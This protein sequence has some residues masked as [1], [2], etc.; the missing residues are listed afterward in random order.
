MDLL[1]KRV[2]VIGLSESGF[3]AAKLLKRVKARVRVSELGDSQLFRKRAEGLSDVECEIGAHTKRFIEESDLIVASP[4]VPMDA[5]PLIWARGRNIPVIS[6][7]E[8]GYLFCSVPIV[9]VTGTNG[10]STTT[11]LIYEMLKSNNIRSYLLGN[12]G[13]PICEDILD[14]P[15]GSVIS[16][17]VSSFQLQTIKSFRPHIAVLLNITQ[18]H[19]DRHSGMEE[20]RNTKL[21]IF[22][23]Q[24][25]GDY[26]ILNYDIPEIRSISDSIKAKVFYFSTAQ[27]VKGTYLENGRI[28]A[29]IDSAP[30]EICKR[31][32]IALPGTHNIEN[33]LAAS[34]ALRLVD[35]KA[36]AVKTLKS[37]RGLR[38]RFE[39]VAEIEGVKYIDDSKSTTVDSTMKALQDFRGSRVILIAGGRDKGSDYSP[40]SGEI[41]KLKYLVLIGEAKEKIKH[42]LSGSDVSVQKSNTLE[43]AVSFSKRIAKAG[44]TV[45]LSPMC[46]SFDMFR[47][48]KERGDVF[49]AAVL[50]ESAARMR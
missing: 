40:I 41:N 35:S 46:S 5:E 37:F 22:E 17:E 38:H 24:K 20:Y 1:N 47:D 16:L 50:G 29:N 34:L 15:A 33:A 49:R 43:E 32:D 30:N 42:D 27:K 36:D 2:T 21:R 10:K 18:D 23:N 11:T 7:L 39:L 14:V 9:A 4:G 25:G 3:S 13:R 12:I 6:E 31:S 19:L 8:L 28:F 48:Y 45:L 26:A 44:D